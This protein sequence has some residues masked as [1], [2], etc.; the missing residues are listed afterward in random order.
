[1]PSVLLLRFIVFLVFLFTKFL[2]GAWIIAI[3][4]PL[5]IFFFYTVNK[6]YERVSHALSTHDLDPKKFSV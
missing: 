5:V 2:E 1:M 4:I 3:I 6:H